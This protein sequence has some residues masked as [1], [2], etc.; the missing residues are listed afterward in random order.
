[1][2]SWQAVLSLFFLQP[3]CGTGTINDNDQHDSGSPADVSVIADASPDADPGADLDG[4]GYSV[5]Q[6]D[7]D[8][9]DP[10]VNPGQAEVPDNGKDDDCDGLVDPY[11]E[12]VVGPEESIGTAGEKLD[13]A[14][15]VDGDLHLVYARG[16]TVYYRHQVN[17]VWELGDQAVP[18][19]E[20]TYWNRWYPRL[21]VDATGGAHVA[22]SDTS[23]ERVYYSSRATAWSGLETPITDGY[24]GLDTNRYAIAVDWND[25]VYVV[26]QSDFAIEYNR[27]PAGGAFEGEQVIYHDDPTEPQFPSVAVSP[28]DGSLHCVYADNTA[29]EGLRYSVFDG[30]WSVSVRPAGDGGGCCAN[31]SDV[32]VA[33]D[34]RAHV[35]WVSWTN[36]GYS[37]LLYVQQQ[38]GGQWS[39]V[40]TFLSQPDYFTCPMD[41]CPIPRVAVS[42]SGAILVV[43]ATGQDT[44]ST[45]S[46]F[47]KLPGE[48][49]PATPE[50]LTT[51]STYQNH[52]AVATAG[53]TFVVLW[54]DGRDGGMIYS[55][56]LSIVEAS[57]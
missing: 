57:R 34:G 24:V 51:G 2:R 20:T 27:K 56:T 28:L 46:Y 31:V 19:S 4:D 9:T 55:R 5:A 49:W 53:D 26:A 33:P 43:Y 6:G 42:D 25:A 30:Q 32:T 40:R 41:D 17:G 11:L 54:N 37:D 48:P 1:M 44:T 15:E 45:I 13:V 16:S 35:A 39:P 3:G 22:W 38:G 23:I 52:P 8:D 18:G 29:G 47:L 50:L 10:A 12:V 21:A 36:D 7:C 14:R